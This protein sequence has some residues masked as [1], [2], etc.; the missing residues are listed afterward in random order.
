M[1]NYEWFIELPID[2]KDIILSLHNNL[3][4]YP[5]AE[6]RKEWIN[7]HHKKIKE[8]INPIIDEYI[9]IL[10]ID[11]ICSLM[12][13]IQQLL[14]EITPEIKRDSNLK[15]TSS[16]N[17]QN[18][19]I[20]LIS[21]NYHLFNI[22]DN[23]I[24]LQLYINYYYW[25]NKINEINNNNNNI[26]IHDKKTINTNLMQELY[27]STTNIIKNINFKLFINNLNEIYECLNKRR[28]FLINY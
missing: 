20:D 24:L 23:N 11:F 19:L 13:L 15:V 22:N 1:N 21:K 18:I 16:I 8:H 9:T 6:W 27:N 26:Y 7:D 2:T 4:K 17:I 5:V 14:Y 10:E 3:K 12:V 25:N 28:E